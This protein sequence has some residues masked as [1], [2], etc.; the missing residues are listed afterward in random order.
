MI[1]S[2]RSSRLVALGGERFA[3]DVKRLSIRGSLFGFVLECRDRVGVILRQKISVAEV[4]KRVGVARGGFR[5]WLQVID[6]VFVL[7]LL[8]QQH[9]DV[10][11]DLEQ[12]QLRRKFLQC[13]HPL[14]DLP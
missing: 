2:R 6:R 4:E 14:L 9:A 3:Q 5:G 1:G 8:Y 7:L 13:R 12:R 11:V 10:V